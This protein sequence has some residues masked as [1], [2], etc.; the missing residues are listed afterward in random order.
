VEEWP[1]ADQV[2]WAK[3]FVPGDPFSPGGLGAGWA[4]ASRQQI[5]AG[6]GKWLVWLDEQGLLDPKAPPASRATR[7]MLAA[8]TKRLQADYSPFT[9]QGR[10]QQVGDALR[11]MAPDQDLRWI[12]RGAWRLRNKAVPITDKRARLQ[13][14]TRLIDL[15]LSLMEDAQAEEVTLA[16]AMTFRDGLIIAFLAFRPLRAK[17]LAMICCGQHLARRG[18]EW[19]VAFAGD[20]MKNKRPLEFPFPA[21]L[22]PHLETYLNIYRPV[23]LTT[24]KPQA[25]A[26]IA[27]LWVSRDATALGQQTIAHH[28]QRRT[29]A[30]FGIALNPHGFRDCA[31]TWI[32]TY[33]PE[34]VQIVAA[35]LG[36]SCMETSERYYNLAR[37][38]EAG[39]RYHA[40]IKVRRDSAGPPADRRRRPA[41]PDEMPSEAGP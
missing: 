29:R 27:R 34:H 33:D 12:S 1:A 37:G 3:A 26:L 6:Y 36:H 23:L 4:L 18:E 7:P 17:N 39:R 38:L 2:A 9:V 15:G 11:I 25:P 19:W 28:I 22:S 32:A 16:S 41:K 5:A 21:A 8:Y 30:E 20:E 10:V 13:S 31:A 24:G 14:P 35:I 40:E